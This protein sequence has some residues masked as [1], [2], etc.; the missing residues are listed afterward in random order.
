MC[1]LLGLDC[2]GVVQRGGRLG[3]G[4]E[5]S[6]RFQGIPDIIQQKFTTFRCL[7]TVFASFYRM[8]AGDPIG[9]SGFLQEVCQLLQDVLQ[10]EFW[11]MDE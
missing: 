10:S 7:E 4:Q 8:S 1:F 11:V 9:S 5:D 6:E 2:A 3:K